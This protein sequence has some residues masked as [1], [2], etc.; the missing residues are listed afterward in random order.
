M[1]TKKYVIALSDE[2]R[3]KLHKIIK[4]GK[5]PARLILRANVLLSSD[6]NATVPLTARETAVLF[7]TSK[8][9]VQNIRT[10]YVK[11]G[12]DGVLYRKKRST[13]PVEPKVDGDVTAHIIALACSEPPEGYERWTVRLLAGKCVELGYIDSISPMTIHRTL[14]KTN[15][16]LT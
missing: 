16:S 15:I 12:L 5:A 8:T 11:N 4:K 6:I 1:P 3:E 10:S 7:K 13:P 14:K 2:E 9:T